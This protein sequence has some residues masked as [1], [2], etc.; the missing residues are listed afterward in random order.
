M[1]HWARERTLTFFDF[2]GLAFIG[3]LILQ[4]QAKEDSVKREE[5]TKQIEEAVRLEKKAFPEGQGTG[6]MG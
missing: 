2:V 6:H 1:C 5:I 3:S 4:T